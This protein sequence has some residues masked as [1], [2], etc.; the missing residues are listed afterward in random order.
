MTGLVLEGGGARGAFQIGAF[1]AIQE[2]GVEIHGIAGTSVGA[3]NGALIAQGDLEKAYQLWRDV[4]P[5][6]VFRLN[7]QGMQNLDRLGLSPENLP[8]L[9]KNLRDIFAEGGLDITPLR[10]L[11]SEVVDEQRIRESGV[12]FGLVAVSLSD[13]KPVELFIEDIPSGKLVDYLLA[14]ASFPGFKADPVEGKRLIDG[15]LHDNMPV[16]LLATRGYKDFIVLRTHGPGRHRRIRQKGL[17]LTYITPSDDLGGIL[18][19]HPDAARA[20]LTMGYYDALKVLK[21]L[22]G[23]RYY[24]RPWEDDFF[25]EHMLG[26]EESMV[27][28]VGRAMGFRGGSYQRML[29]ERIIPRYADLMGIDRQ[30][31]YEEI[32][33][34]LLEEIA[35]RCAVERFHIYELPEF[36]DRIKACYQ[37]VAKGKLQRFPDL[38]KQNRVLSRTVRGSILGDSIDR[39]FQDWAG[40][41]SDGKHNT[42]PGGKL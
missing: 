6:Q 10:E 25:L 19:F 21:G 2:M 5:A 20:N 33:L 36:V 27:R 31:G 18:S 7:K 24:L 28:D 9:L 13:W 29:F 1:Q 3:L 4:N 26:L 42:G 40:P 14:S 15:G 11:V 32:G 17:R 37:P 22:K 8:R 39:L 41:V 16:G 35:A 38:I 30:A 12:D 34:V 23:R